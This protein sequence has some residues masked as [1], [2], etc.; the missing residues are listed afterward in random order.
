MILIKSSETPDLIGLNN[1]SLALDE[2]YLVTD[3]NA[4]TYSSDPSSLINV[5]G[6]LY[7]TAN[8]NTNGIELYQTDPTTGVVSLIEINPGVDSSYPDNLTNVNGTLYFRA[9]D[10]TNAYQLWKIGTNGTPTLIDLGNGA[11]YPDNLTNINNILYFTAYTSV[12]GYQLWKI[13]PTTANPSVIDLVSGS[14]SYSPSN[15]TNIN[16]TGLTQVAQIGG[17]ASRK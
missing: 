3:I 9:Y 12:N 10:T 7:F 16:G 1:G 6:I 15:L 14:G 13:D 8:N 5:G 17:V 11:S 4:T 2:P